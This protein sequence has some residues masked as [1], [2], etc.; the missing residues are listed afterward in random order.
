VPG[1]TV[2]T[3]GVMPRV[4]VSPTGESFSLPE[5]DDYAIELERLETLAAEA[6]GDG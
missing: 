2:K 5:S 3:G 4:S 1:I 6:R